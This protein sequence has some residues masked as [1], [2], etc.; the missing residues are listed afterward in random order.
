ML[1]AIYEYKN[2]KGL[3]SLELFGDARWSDIDKIME[4]L[5]S[6]AQNYY[7][8]GKHEKKDYILNEICPMVEGYLKALRIA[9]YKP[10]LFF[11]YKFTI[12]TGI[13]CNLGRAILEFKGLTRKENEPLTPTYEK[14][15]GKVNSKMTKESI[16]WRL[17][18]SEDN[19]ILIEKHNLGYRSAIAGSLIHE[20]SKKIYLSDLDE[21][22]EN[23]DLKKKYLLPGQRRE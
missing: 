10:S 7:N 2:I 11:D 17:S 9:G 12:D 3:K 18:C 6:N 4:I 13:I 16:I 15:Y 23:K 8:I 22:V 1:N 14:N 19:T 20:E 21:M 5:K